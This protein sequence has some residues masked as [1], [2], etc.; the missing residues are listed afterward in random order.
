MIGAVELVAGIAVAGMIAVRRFAAEAEVSEVLAA[1]AEVLA[2]ATAE[3][4]VAA[5]I[6]AEEAGIVVEA[7]AVR[8]V[9]EDDPAPGL[10]SVRAIAM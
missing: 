8:K 1:A 3:I 10:A 2:A 9:E 6:A 7:V 4:A 5:E